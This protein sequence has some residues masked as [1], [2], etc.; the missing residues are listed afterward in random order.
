VQR[1]GAGVSVEVLPSEKARPI[2]TLSRADI[3]VTD[4]QME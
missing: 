4:F 3:F 2:H 1:N